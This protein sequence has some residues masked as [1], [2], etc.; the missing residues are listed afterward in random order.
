MAKTMW[1]AL[2]L[3]M[4]SLAG[5]TKLSAGQA[6]GEGEFRKFCAECHVDGGN[7]VKPSKTLFEKDR[8]VNGIKTAD[9]II[10]LMRNPGEG[11]TRFDEETVPENEARKIAEY[12]LKTFKQL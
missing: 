1:G 3:V 12:I 9:D 7:I 4:L 5:V 10:R 6:V 8:S 2:F 11:M